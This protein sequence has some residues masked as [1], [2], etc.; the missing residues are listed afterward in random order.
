[1]VGAI[2]HQ[3]RVNGLTV[4]IGSRQRVNNHTIRAVNHLTGDESGNHLTPGSR[5]KVSVKDL[6]S[7]VVKNLTNDG[8][9]LRGGVSSVNG[10]SVCYVYPLWCRKL[11]GTLC[12]A[13]AHALYTV[14]YSVPFPFLLTF[15]YVRCPL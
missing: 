9:E 4:L 11:M 8:G 12:S 6:A 5:M 1:M 13:R 15:V 2:G 14:Y 10:L 3:R 7:V